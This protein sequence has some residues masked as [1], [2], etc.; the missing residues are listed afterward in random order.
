MEIQKFN[1][2]SDTMDFNAD[3]YFYEIFLKKRWIP[4]YYNR[5]RYFMFLYRGKVSYLSEFTISLILCSVVFISTIGIRKLVQRFKLKRKINRLIKKLRAGS[6]SLGDIVQY[7]ESF[8]DEIIG[9]N[10][11]DLSH[12]TLSARQKVIKSIIKKCLKPKRHYKIINRQILE[13][14]DKM[15]NYKKK[16]NL[17]IISYDVFVLALS[18]AFKPA[19]MVGFK[20]IIE[21]FVNPFILENSPIILSILTA[22]SLA[23]KFD[24]TLGAFQLG[25]QTLWMLFKSITV[26]GFTEVF[27]ATYLIDCG[28]YV[29]E[30]PQAEVKQLPDNHNLPESESDISNVSYIRENPNPASTYVSTNPGSSLYIQE[31]ADQGGFLP[32]ETLDGSVKQ[33]R[34]VNG[35]TTVD[36]VPNRDIKVSKRQQRYIPLGDRT[37]TILDVQKLDSTFDKEATDEIIKAVAKEQVIALRLETVINGE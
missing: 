32:I 24:L 8:T 2:F 25:T 12:F 11:F 27:R 34:K 13:L 30:L 17:K 21:K 5:R 4:F 33:T 14:I 3:F 10:P 23:I 1:N 28:D 29:A 15:M 37:R 31:D 19:I 16:D 20:G 36:W 26:F 35:Q 18:I 22:F 7:E 9:Y 6:T